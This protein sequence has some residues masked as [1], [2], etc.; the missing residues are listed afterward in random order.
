MKIVFVDTSGFYAV[1]NGSDSFHKIAAAAFVRAEEEKWTLVTTNYVVHE[2]W[3]LVQNRLGWD[4]LDAF[5]DSILPLCRVDF[6]DEHLHTLGEGRCRQ[7]RSRRLSLTDCISLE[8]MKGHDIIE[9]IA[10]D[11]HFSQAKIVL[12]I[13]V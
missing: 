6:V 12:P 1:L 4:A 10:C 2:T 11:E 13:K 5:F 9:A 7:A 8:Y 3:A